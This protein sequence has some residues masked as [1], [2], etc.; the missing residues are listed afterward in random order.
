V[1][2]GCPENNQARPRAAAVKNPPE[3]HFQLF[4]SFRRTASLKDSYAVN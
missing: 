3:T 1:A 2:R 4:Y